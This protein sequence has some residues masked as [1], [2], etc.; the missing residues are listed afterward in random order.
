[1]KNWSAARRG[2]RSST[3]GRS[4]WSP[5][6]RPVSGRDLSGGRA[7]RP[8]RPLGRE[9]LAHPPPGSEPPARGQDL[10][11][12]CSPQVDV[13]PGLAGEASR[14]D[15]PI[16]A[17]R[18]NAGT[19]PTPPAKSRRDGRVPFSRPSGTYNIAASSTPAMNRWAIFAP[20]LRHEFGFLDEQPRIRLTELWETASLQGRS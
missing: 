11:A 14:R 18:F 17:Q 7:P 9:L 1:M 15:E 5:G 8:R 3:M 16:L 12:C 10:Q 13:V 4:T 20:C 2:L 6:L 19:T